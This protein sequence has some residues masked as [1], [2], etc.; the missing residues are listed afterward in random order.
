MKLTPQR[1]YRT[2]ADVVRDRRFDD[3]ERLEILEAWHGLVE[4]GTTEQQMVVDAMADVERKRAS[5]N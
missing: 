5:G 1:F 2:P 3:T 4:A